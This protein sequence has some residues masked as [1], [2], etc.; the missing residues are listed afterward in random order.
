MVSCIMTVCRDGDELGWHYDPND[1]VVSLLLQAAEQGGG[2]EFV[3]DLRGDLRGDDAAATARE[4]DVLDGDGPDILRPR[5]EPG[6]L[7]LFNGY[8]SLHR[9]A[10]VGPGRERIMALFS[11]ARTPGYVFSPKIREN[12]FGR[13]D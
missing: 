3:P 8:R 12:F 1:G 2:F 6:T 5:Q 9:V 7:S 10:P 13:A 11:Y 4:L